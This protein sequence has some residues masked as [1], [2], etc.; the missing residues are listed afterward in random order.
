MSISRDGFV[1]CKDE[2]RAGNLRAPDHPLN[3]LDY[4]EYVRETDAAGNPRFRLD[5]VFLKNAPTDLVGAPQAF[6]VIGGVRVVGI[7]VLDVTGDSVNS[8]CLHVFVDAEGDFSTYVLR[9]EHDAIDKQRAEASFS[10]RAGCPT[11][12]DCRQRIPCPPEAL[13]EPALD[14]LSKDYQSFRRLMLDLIPER[15]PGW[16]ER[17]PADLGMAIVEL[18]AYAGDYLSYYQDVAGTEGYLDSCLHRV[19]AARHARL[20]DYRMHHGRNA[21]TYVHFAAEPGTDGV[22]PAG[23]NLLT[24]VGEPLRGKSAPPGLVIPE[25]DNPDFDSDAALADVTIFE[26]TAI[27]RVTELHNELRIHTWGDAEC[28]LARGAR[29]AFLYGIPATGTDPNAFPPELREG[30]YLLLEEIRS[31]VTG[32]AADADPL[33]RQ[34]VRL[35]DVK[36]DKDT[37]YHRVMTGRQLTPRKSETDPSLPLLRVTWRV[38]DALRFPLCLS[39]QTPETGPVDPVSV[40]RGNVAPADHGRTIERDTKVVTDAADEKQAELPPSPGTGRWQLPWPDAAP[41]THQVLPD[42]PQYAE[43]NR[44]CTGRHDLERDARQT[45]PAIVLTLRFPGDQKERWVPVPHLLDSGPHSEHFIA[46]IADQGEALLRFG[47]DQYGRRP[48]GVEH[49]NARFRV[50]NGTA[51]NIGAGTLVHI[52]EPSAALLTDPADPDAGPATFAS[53]ARIHQ[54]LAARLGTDPET[55]EQ[56]RQLAPEAFRAIQYRAV[57]EA[58]WQEVA[59]RHPGVAAAKARFRWTGSWHTVFVAIHPVDAENL[60]RLAGGGAALA[61]DFATE[62]KAHLTR[63]KIAGYDLTVRAAQY[64]PLEIALRV[65]VTPGHFRGDVL[66]AVARALSNR[67]FADGTSGLFHS[68]Q[69]SFGEPVFLSRV[70]AA[71]EAVEGVESVTVMVFK[72]YWET[73]QDEIERGFISLEELEIARLDNDPNFPE[74]GVLHLTAVGGL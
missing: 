63:F 50:G 41:L 35:V 43:D 67:S 11:L 20:I 52:V 19:S 62:M 28:C 13:E 17:L 1:G 54:P 38:E 4:V 49:V 37:A 64:V 6:S 7:R 33:H 29:E 3:G 16:L 40:A 32:A 44:L 9:V 65:C 8:K 2:R 59:Q 72:R 42:E 34:V 53:I 23:A 69:L 39:A 61:A 45:M 21:V 12:F 66:E 60:A 27:T 30:D 18:F 24:R 73:Q 47:D 5:A 58:D 55:I 70:Y 68:P 46:E 51:G 48:L 14:Y 71:V 26:T 36:E 31:P 56:V 22:V 74:S 15:N 25:D 57:T 10:F